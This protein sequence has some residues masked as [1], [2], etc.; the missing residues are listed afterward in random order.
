MINDQERSRKKD[1]RLSRCQVVQSIRSRLVV[2][3]RPVLHA[4]KL[5]SVLHRDSLWYIESQTL[6]MAHSGNEHQKEYYSS[7]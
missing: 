7:S 4:S 5:Y 2:L 1:P 3:G 6:V